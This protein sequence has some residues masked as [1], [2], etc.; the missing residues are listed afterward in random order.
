MTD[1]TAMHS[2][3]TKQPKA[4]KFSNLESKAASKDE[5][6]NVAKGS[7]IR[8]YELANAGFEMQDFKFFP[9]DFEEVKARLSDFIVTDESTT[10]DKVFR[11]ERLPY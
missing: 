3:I 5:G 7:D 4:T 11:F 9:A 2:T 8:P 10:L 1:S 6:F